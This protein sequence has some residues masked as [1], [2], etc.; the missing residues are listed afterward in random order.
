MSILVLW[1]G[2]ERKAG[3]LPDKWPMTRF[4]QPTG[5]ESSSFMFFKKTAFIAGVERGLARGH[6]IL[7]KGAKYFEAVINVGLTGVF[8]VIKPLARK[9]FGYG[10]IH[11]PIAS[12]LLKAD[13]SAKATAGKSENYSASAPRS[14]A[15]EQDDM[16][17]LAVFLACG[18]PSNKAGKKMR[19]DGGLCI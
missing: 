7:M 17:S 8:C 4:L 3:H 12:D 2:Y 5:K 11:N 16:S 10:F 1:L 6:S 9:F 18:G 15:G 19:F 14:R 13:I